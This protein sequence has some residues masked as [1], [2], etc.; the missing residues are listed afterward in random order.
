METCQIAVALF[1]MQHQIWTLSVM[2]SINLKFGF[3]VRVCLLLFYKAVFTC[4]LG[5]S[6]LDFSKDKPKLEM[7]FL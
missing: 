5:S 3:S 6:R 1:P 2:K 4:A 7:A